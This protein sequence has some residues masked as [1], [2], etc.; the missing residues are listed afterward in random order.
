MSEK[1]RDNPLREIISNKKDKLF[2][3]RAT[4]IIKRYEDY[5]DNCVLNP[6]EYINIALLIVHHPNR[7]KFIDEKLLKKLDNQICSLPEQLP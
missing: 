7:L 4:W 1:Q 5:P 3:D 6:N 2:V